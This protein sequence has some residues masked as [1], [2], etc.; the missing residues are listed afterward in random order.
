MHMEIGM[1]GHFLADGTPSGFFAA[2]IMIPTAE[3]ARLGL[4]DHEKPS[5][6][7]ACLRWCHASFG[8]GGTR[9]IVRMPPD[10]D[11][12]LYV[13]EREDALAF[14]AHWADAA[15]ADRP[16]VAG[17]RSLARGLRQQLPA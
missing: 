17:R 14:L 13:A 1:F 9:W 4:G 10:A 12:V 11:A 6:I 15:V 5:S 7:P 16:L 8:A 2:R 3:F